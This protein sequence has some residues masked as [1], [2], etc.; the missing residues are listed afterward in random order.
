MK[1]YILLITIAI[2]YC[3]LSVNAQVNKA[4]LLDGA[5]VDSAKADSY[6]LYAKVADSVWLMKMYDL[7]DSI[8]VMGHFS[9]EKLSIPD[10]GFKYYHYSKL[11]KTQKLNKTNG[12]NYLVTIGRYEKGLK[13][14]VW[15][16]LFS[17]GNVAALNTYLNDK[18]NG[19]YKTYNFDNGAV[20]VEGNY[21]SDK[22]E[23]EWYVL[24]RN[25]NILET[26]IYKDGV[27]LRRI[28]KPSA[29]NPPAPPPEFYSYFSRA[30]SKYT[31]IDIN[32]TVYIGVTVS[33]EGKIT[34]ALINDK[35]NLNAEFIAKLKEIA[36]SSPM[37]TPANDSA[38]KKNIE[39][40]A[41]IIVKIKAGEV[42]T[43]LMDYHGTDH[44][45]YGIQH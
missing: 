25:G 16:E 28:N 43:T 1:K 13:S 9:D 17:N 14:G 37:W 22:R 3:T 41:S 32:E 36:L 18:L 21:I 26:D 35:R 40:L 2:I 23:G 20:V 12:V 6:I 33:A 8:M 30:V 45:F 38:L 7:H 44:T 15:K 31:N 39:G 27:V 10:G 5:P 29:Y 11:S 19:P 24:G 34:E 42:T 4:F